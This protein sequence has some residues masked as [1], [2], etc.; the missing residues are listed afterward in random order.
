MLPP[1]VDI[2]IHIPQHPIRGHFVDGIPDETYLIGLIRQ[3]VELNE[4]GVKLPK[5]SNPAKKPLI[6]MP[7]PLA[8]A[9]SKSPKAKT[10]FEGL[11]PSCKREYLEWITEAKRDETRDK[12]I[13]Q[14]VEWL[15]EGKKRNWKYEKC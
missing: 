6:K 14:A 11:A 2:H 5:R 15:S 13:A 3:G 1:L 7:K 4:Q 12:R 10:F 9:L 8:M